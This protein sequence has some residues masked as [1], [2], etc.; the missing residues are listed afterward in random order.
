M[1][2]SRCPNYPA[3]QRSK[4]NQIQETISVQVTK[5]FWQLPF[6]RADRSKIIQ[7]GREANI[8]E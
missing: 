5:V 8:T 7:C 4:I 2:C 1:Q 3:I 6:P